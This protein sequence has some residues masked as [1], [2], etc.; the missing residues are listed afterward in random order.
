M[1]K[2]Y[3]ILYRVFSLLSFLL[4]FAPFCG[5]VIAGL[6]S[7]CLVVEKVGLLSTVLIVGIL[8]AISLVNKIALRSRLWI[9]LIGLYVCL[10]NIM[11]PLIIIACCQVVDE[12]ICTPLAKI[13]REKMVINRELDKRI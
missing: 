12:L 2:R 10:G 3:T 13:F 8:T 5:Y 9:L 1:T 11:T 7:D 4:M 6:C